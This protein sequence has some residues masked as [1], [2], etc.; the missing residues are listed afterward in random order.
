MK[1]IAILF[2]IVLVF[3]AAPH[4]VRALQSDAP[5][6]QPSAEGAPKEDLT[7][8]V[9]EAVDPLRSELMELAFRA[10]S[11]MPNHPHI[12]NRSRAQEQAIDLALEL[13]QGNRVLEYAE[14]IDNWR[15]ASAYAKYAEY[16]ASLG[17]RS[18]AE[19]YVAK[20]RAT[21]EH[22]LANPTV[23]ES[24]QPWM[25]ERIRVVLAKAHYHMG[26]QDAGREIVQ[27]LGDESNAA[28]RAIGMEN[29]TEEHFEGKLAE[30][31][32]E[33]GRGGID[34]VRFGLETAV[35]LHGHFFADAEKRALL[36]G[37]V[38]DS[39]RPVPLAVR[40]QFLTTM[41]RSAA[42]HGDQAHA[43]GLLDEARAQLDSAN[44]LVPDRLPLVA[45]L[46]EGQHAAG[47]T[48]GAAKALE[49]GLALFQ[50][51]RERIPDVFRGEALRP[52][53]EAYQHMGQS[54]EA[55]AVYRQALDEGLINPNSRPRAEDLVATACSMARTRA[56]VDAAL[57]ARLRAA[58][59]ALGEP[60]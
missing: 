52:V 4:T 50:T 44:W 16:A 20:S 9:D 33:I 12:K 21:L 25:A 41:A 55:L 48:D 32:G 26:K 35:Q 46:A 38:R 28:V 29:L 24:V 49:E 7:A 5:G 42:E 1:P 13:G 37:I 36:E 56:P 23:Y 17:H 15:R 30:V 31:R 6:E 22:H 47:D 58:V 2:A 54:E 59:E 60:W 18:L 19:S 27:H 43:L 3:S 8:P 51:E 57:L 53:A 14:R 45:L 10:A 40:I 39:W 11:A 34:P